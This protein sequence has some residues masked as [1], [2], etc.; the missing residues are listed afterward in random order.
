MGL[1]YL[2]SDEI[3]WMGCLDLPTSGVRMWKSLD[4]GLNWTQMTTAEGLPDASTATL[5]RSS[6]APRTYGTL[7]TYI[8]KTATGNGYYR[9]LDNGVTWTQML[10]GSAF[11]GQYTSIAIDKT[12]G[13][14]YVVLSTFIYRSL[15]NGVTWTAVLSSLT[16]QHRLALNSLGHIFV[17][18]SSDGLLRKSFD[19][20]ASWT[21]QAWGNALVVAADSQDRIFVA[22]SNTGYYTLDRGETKT[23]FT[24]G[25]A[26]TRW[27]AFCDSNNQVFIGGDD[28]GGRLFRSTNHGTSFS[29]VYNA[30]AGVGNTVQDVCEDKFGRLYFASNVLGLFRSL[31]G[32]ATWSLLYSETN[33]L[34]TIHAQ[35][36]VY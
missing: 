31:D 34:Y 30:G 29:T 7:F 19:K 36:R 15:D 28:T 12:D 16:G 13:T 5:V 35:K 14:I 33:Q 2:P 3:L 8:R 25:S 9:S 18:G 4:H 22:N 21:T 6:L 26:G 32:G 17:V 23:A 20:G 24:T 1:A 11:N 27:S 10:A